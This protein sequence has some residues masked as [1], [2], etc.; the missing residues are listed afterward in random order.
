MP[1]SAGPHPITFADFRA[2]AAT[3]LLAKAPANAFDPDIIPLMGDHRLAERVAPDD[4]ALHRPAAVL[5]PII[6]RPEGAT[7]LLTKRSAHLKDHAGQV[8]FPGGKMDQN[9]SDPVETALRE[10]EEEIGL[11]HRYI[12]PIGYLEP[13]LSSTGFTIVPVVAA[14]D[15][16]HHLSLDPNEVELTFEVPLIFLM[17]PIYHETHSREWRGALR[18]YYAMPYKDHYIWGVTAGIIRNL[19]EKVYGE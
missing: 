3:R 9:E 1:S 5:I 11:G 4:G 15:P 6:A 7:M 10:A 16:S 2:R 18:Q 14:I 17:N 13:Y 19:Y 8:A 12:E